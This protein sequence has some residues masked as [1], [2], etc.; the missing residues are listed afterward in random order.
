I[1]NGCESVDVVTV[2]VTIHNIPAPTGE[3]TQSFCEMNNPTVADLVVNGTAVKWYASIDATVA[4]PIDNALEDGVMYFASQTVNN[5]ES[6]G[7]LAV[8][9]SINEILVPTIE[10]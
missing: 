4:L 8:T 7:R 9:V 6:E 10:N 1:I 2:N 3:T 5:C